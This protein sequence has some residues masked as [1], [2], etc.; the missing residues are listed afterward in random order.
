MLFTT[1]AELRPSTARG[2]LHDVRPGDRHDLKR[3]ANALDRVAPEER[4]RLAGGAEP[5]DDLAEHRPAREHF[6][7]GQERLGRAAGRARRRLRARGFAGRR[8]LD[9]RTRPILGRTGTR[10]TE[11]DRCGGDEDAEEDEQ[12]APVRARRRRGHERRVGEPGGLNA[13]G[14]RR[15]FHRANR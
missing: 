6:D 2:D 10:V 8:D 1:A 15:R 13:V 3:R 14:V 12:P 5:R 7:L 11:S 9:A 4:E